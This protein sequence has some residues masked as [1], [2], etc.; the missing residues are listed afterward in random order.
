MFNEIC[1]LHTLLLFLAPSLGLALEF[2]GIGDLPGGSFY[3]TAGA[4]SKNGSYLVGESNSSLGNEGFIYDISAS[5]SEA[6]SDL[7]GGDFRISSYGVANTGRVVGYS[8]SA[9]GA[10]AF[11]RDHTSVTQP[12]G[13]LPGGAFWSVAYGISMSE[14][15]IVGRSYTDAGIEAFRWTEE[16]GMTSLKQKLGNPSASAASGISPDGKF[17]IGSVDFSASQ[18]GEGFFWSEE[19]G[20]KRIG[21]LPSDG[22]RNSSSPTAITNNANVIVGESN[23]QAFRWTPKNGIE[24]LGFLESVSSGDQSHATDVSADGKIVVGW[25]LS[26]IGNRERGGE[27]TAF[28]WT[29]ETGMVALDEVLVAN[30]LAVDG[31][32]LR[33]ANGISADGTRIVGEGQNPDGSTEAFLVTD[34]SVENILRLTRAAI[35]VEQEAKSGAVD[36]G[37]GTGQS[38][39]LPAGQTVAAIQLHIGSVGNGG[40]SINVRLWEATGGPG[41]HFTR[42]GGELIATGELDRSAVFGTPDWFT[43]NLDQSFTNSGNES[44]YLVFDIELLSSGSEGW[45]NYS[46]SDENSYDGGHSVY[47]HADN[48]VIRDGQD[49]SF[50]ILNERAEE[51]SVP[52]PKVEFSFEPAAPGRLASSNVLIRESIVGFEYTCFMS[53]DLSL[54]RKQW[55]KMWTEVG[56]GGPVDWGVG[57]G[58]VPS[59]IFF[60]V[61]VKP[62]Q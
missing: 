58:S 47:W 39:L 59:S 40:G 1:K 56:Y 30:G 51:V 13:D 62:T 52:I 11:Y 6:I 16:S 29:E 9:N 48:Y 3:S 21:K 35:V 19:T 17:V 20:I 7:D 41:S 61:E 45:N 49:L 46:Y 25:S 27:E 14:E 23:S 22:G 55:D 4:L 37:T 33:S 38:F 53:E 31:W 32:I 26:S 54:P 10:E 2:K 12:M 50:R 5:T 57:Y 43:I 34:F 60:F 28:V 44:V 8:H 18:G 15:V 36:Y 24:G 42:L